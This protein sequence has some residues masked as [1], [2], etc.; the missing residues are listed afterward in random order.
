MS[1]DIR[2]IIIIGSGPAGLTAAI[3]AA[4]ANLNPLVFAG[5]LYGGQLMLTSD[6]ENY[7]GFPDGI[8][9]PE[10]M[11]KFRAQAV[12]FGAEIH[13]E[14]VT[15]VEF[16]GTRRR[17]W[18]HEHEYEAET[19][20]VATGASSL[21]LGL[22]NETRLRGRGV[23]T[24]A[25]CDGAFFKD[26]EILVV[27]GGDSA[28]EEALFLTHFGTRVTVV[29]RRDQL[30]ASKIMQHRAKKHPKIEFV[31]NAAVD[32]VLG[33]RKV[34]AVVLRDTITGVKTERP[35]D[36]VFVAIGHV[37]NTDIFS[38]QLALDERGYIIAPDGVRTNVEGVFVAG[39]VQDVHYRQAVTAAGLGCRAAIEA[40]RYLEA[41]EAQTAAVR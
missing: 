11:E 31:W 26:K 16:S 22:E 17:V 1:G 19:I 10:L 41:R 34:H 20:V 7:P 23:S 38:G 36:A 12:R 33:D 3:Y 27:G 2:K 32:D 35:A 37:P 6:V 39:D 5:G 30:R 29:H 4:R 24:C 13:N 40:E 8:T 9:G 15:R 14:D 18:V 21:W 25:T 28:L